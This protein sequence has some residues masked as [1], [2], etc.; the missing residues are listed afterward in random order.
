MRFQPMQWVR[1]QMF[2][3][4][5]DDGAL[6]WNENDSHLPEFKIRPGECGFNLWV[7]WQMFKNNLYYYPD[8]WAVA[9]KIEAGSDYEYVGP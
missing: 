9:I 2:S 4:V 5:T 6:I 8:L 1:W 7:R 3:T